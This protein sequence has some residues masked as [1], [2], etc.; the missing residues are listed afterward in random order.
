MTTR[1]AQLGACGQSVWLDSISRDWILSG[2]LSEM[3]EEL[4]ITGLTSNP[5]IFEAALRSAT[6]D[7]AIR[8]LVAA[9]HTDREIFEQLAVEDIRAACDIL[10]DA[11]KRSGGVDGMVS[12]ELEP[13]LAHDTAQSIV[14]ARELWN[15]V[16]R[17]N[18]MIK[19]P[20][21]EAGFE[22]VETLISEGIN[23]NVTLLF[24]VAA[25]RT[26]MDRYVTA[27]ER[28]VA[29]GEHPAVHSV[30]SFFVSRIDTAVDAELEARDVGEHLRG[31]IAVANAIAAWDAY[32]D[33]FT[34]DR[35][36]ALQRHGARPQRPLWASTGT[37]NPEYSDILYVQDLIVA[38]SVNTMPLATMRAF[39][40]HGDA[41]ITI[42]DD[43]RREARALLGDLRGTGVDLDGITERL[44]CDG[45]DAFQQS[46]DTLLERIA[47]RRTSFELS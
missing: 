46:F 36:L 40:D 35:F 6:Y 44:R 28:R 34:S 12:M 2:E 7:D 9:G 24:S 45:V 32:L 26:V 41:R 31:R 25:Y 39:Q 23:V 33:V 43:A 27:L 4:S 30:A 5:S 29:A 21:T 14:R 19:V 47:S 10:R 20:A 37:K 42:T 1:L 22:V 17:P 13:D 18:L 3:V 15:L 38:G 11:W 8:V 16:G